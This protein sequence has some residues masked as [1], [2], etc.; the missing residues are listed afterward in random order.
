MLLIL[1][2]A[3]SKMT[4][5]YWKC[6]WQQKP[7][8]GSRKSY[9]ISLKGLETKCNIIV[10]LLLYALKLQH[11]VSPLQIGFHYSDYFACS[12]ALCVHFLLLFHLSYYLLVQ[13]TSWQPFM[14]D[15]TNVK[16]W[17]PILKMFVKDCM[18]L[19][20]TKGQKHKPSAISS[21]SFICKMTP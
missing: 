18:I 10:Q 21:S 13:V 5:L 12:V 16:L 4:P 7:L 19:Q 9:M 20:Y 6:M 15:I 3:L 1:T 14:M 17:L 2:R 11:T 8:M